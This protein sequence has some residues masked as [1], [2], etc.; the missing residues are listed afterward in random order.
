MK[1]TIKID[2]NFYGKPSIEILADYSSKDVRDKLVCN[3]ISHVQQ[4]GLEVLNYGGVSDGVQQYYLSPKQV[5]SEP[6]ELTPD[7]TPTI[8]IMA[9]SQTS[10]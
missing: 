8:T 6:A 10:S 4:F 5:H 1:S 9:S 3:F 2:V 7:P